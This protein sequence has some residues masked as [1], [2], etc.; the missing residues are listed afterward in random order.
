M[1]TSTTL[2][3][4]L[5]FYL[6]RFDDAVHGSDLMEEETGALEEL[7]NEYSRFILNEEYIKRWDQLAD[8]HLVDQ[9]RN[10]SALS[11]AKLE[12]QR[13][14]KL[15]MDEGEIADYFQNI[16]SSIEEEFGQFQVTGEST[17]LLVGSGSF[18]MTP[19]LIAGRT[20]ARVIGIDIDEEAI[21]LGRQVVDRLGEHLTITLELS[22]VEQLSEL[23]EVTHIIFSST[24]GAKYDILDQVHGLIDGEV[25]VS[26]R[27]GNGLKSLFNFPSREV[28]QKKWRIAENSLRPHQIFDILLYEKICSSTSHGRIDE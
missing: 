22:S 11:V 5:R 16:E 3:E 9:L 4:D 12:K 24:V 10:L 18:P 21:I 27:Y 1:K 7:I 14:R 25:V 2:E 23:N 8:P 15:L 19:L 28:D 20:G 6:K 26:M 13:A 17:V